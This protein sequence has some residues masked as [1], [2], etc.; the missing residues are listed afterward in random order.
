L[1]IGEQVQLAL[2]RLK[3]RLNPYPAPN[4]IERAAENAFRQQREEAARSGHG[5][6]GL[7][8]VEPDFI[9]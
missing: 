9:C 7:D 5:N 3:V 8:T 6:A 4:F 2:E 1:S